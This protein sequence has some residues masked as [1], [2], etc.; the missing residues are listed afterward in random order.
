MILLNTGLG[1]AEESSRIKELLHVEESALTE[2]ASK[3][4]F[5]YNT[6]IICS[7]NTCLLTS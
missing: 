2:D 5:Y 7:N 6:F 4:I 1:G 3:L